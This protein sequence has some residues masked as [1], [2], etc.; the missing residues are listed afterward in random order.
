MGR[1]VKSIL[2]PLA[3]FSLLSQPFTGK[4]M[5]SDTVSA[6]LFCALTAYLSLIG[7]WN[8]TGWRWVNHTLLEWR[9]CHFPQSI[10]LSLLCNFLVFLPC[11]PLVQ[12][13]ISDLSVLHSFIVIIAL[14][15]LCPLEKTLSHYTWFRPFTQYVFTFNNT[16]IYLSLLL[17]L[18]LF[19]SLMLFSLCASEILFFLVVDTTLCKLLPLTFP[20]LFHFSIHDPFSSSKSLNSRSCLF[21][22]TFSIILQ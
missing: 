12:H 11:Y 18:L 7:R 3:Q 21:Y 5:Q 1:S 4:A 14:L 10:P 15:P 2:E 16:F 19:A 9:K 6:S 17:L 8:H 20:S 13:C 22:V